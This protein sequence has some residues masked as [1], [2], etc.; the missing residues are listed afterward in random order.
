MFRPR[1]GIFVFARR[2]ERLL[3]PPSNPIY[4]IRGSVPL[5]YIAYR[6]YECAEF[7]LFA[8]VTWCLGAGVPCVYLQPSFTVISEWVILPL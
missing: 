4:P 6:G 2:V 3:D 5:A 7:F 1:V 8:L